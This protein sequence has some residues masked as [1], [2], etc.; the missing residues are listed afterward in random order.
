MLKANSP[1]IAVTQRWQCL[2]GALTG[3]LE[4]AVAGLVWMVN[5]LLIVSPVE[6]CFTEG[7]PAW[8]GKAVT[9]AALGFLVN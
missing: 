5:Y 7:L 9:W 1:L 6:R 8:L 2:A 3:N 4:C